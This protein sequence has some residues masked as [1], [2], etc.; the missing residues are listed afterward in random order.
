MKRIVKRGLTLCMLLFMLTACAGG[1]PDINTDVPGAATTGSDGLAIVATIFPEYDWV[2]NIMGDRAQSADITLLMDNGVDMHSF[3]PTAGD[4]LKI[5][6]CDLF[7]YVGGESDE[8]VEDALAEAV[9]KDMVVV[10]LMDVLGD[11]VKEEETVEGM[12]TEDDHDDKSGGEETGPENDEHVW[13]SLRN[14]EVL[15]DSITDALCTVDSEG[16]ETYRAN[17]DKYQA[18]LK[19]LDD[20]YSKAVDESPVRTLLFGDRFPFRYMTDDYALD[21]YAAFAGCSAETEASFETVIFLANKVDEL[22]LDAVMTIDGSDGKVARTIID[23]TSTRDQEILM[24]NSMQGV[25]AQDIDSGTTYLSVM[26]SNLEVLEEA[27][28]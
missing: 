24:L 21:Y 25:T 1:S 2:M 17:N 6:S 4:I 14:A 7:I 8:W 5:S 9:N 20:D 11:R 18:S 28:K 23:N 10:N 27:L 26:R 3:Q 12:E 13:L 16:T 22:G 15:C 19:S